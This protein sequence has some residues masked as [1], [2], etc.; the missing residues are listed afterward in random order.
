[1]LKY[2]RNIQAVKTSFT[3]FLDTL[4]IMFNAKYLIDFFPLKIKASRKCVLQLHRVACLS[5][6]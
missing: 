1:M 3:N 2:L 5:T 6:N 4:S